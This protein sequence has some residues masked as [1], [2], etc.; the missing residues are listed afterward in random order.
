MAA[1]NYF[2]QFTAGKCKTVIKASE[3]KSE[4][5]KHRTKWH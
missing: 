4:G 2:C 1:K 3:I 5:P